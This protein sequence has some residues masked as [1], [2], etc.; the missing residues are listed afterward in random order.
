MA[1]GTQR[2]TVDAIVQTKGVAR[3]IRYTA[4]AGLIEVV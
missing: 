2:L 4:G 3:R 1:G